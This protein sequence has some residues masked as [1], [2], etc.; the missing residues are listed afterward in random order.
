MY[1]YFRYLQI[2]E[3][4]SHAGL[5][6]HH[7][8]SSTKKKLTCELVL[9]TKFINLKCYCLIKIHRHI[10]LPTLHESVITIY[11]Q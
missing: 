3:E 6:D 7:F 11:L 5:Q 2:S 8:S 10:N 9:R 4:N 1:F